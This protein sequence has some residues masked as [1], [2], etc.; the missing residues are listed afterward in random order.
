VL[1]K[2][3]VIAEE[4]YSFPGDISFDSFPGDISFDSFPG[5]IG[6]L[7]NHIF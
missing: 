3:H 1:S 5:D 2:S 7:K 6:F 4:F